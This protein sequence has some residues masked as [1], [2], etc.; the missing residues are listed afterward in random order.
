VIGVVAGTGSLVDTR[1]V[2]VWLSGIAGAIHSERD[3]LTQ[4][5]AAIGDGDHGTNMDRGFTA[6]SQAVAGQPDDLPPGK[7]LVLAGKTRV[8]TVG[9]ASRPLW[10]SAL[11]RA[12]RVLGD[13]PEFELAQ[14]C[15]MFDAALDGVVELGAA[16]PGD[17]TM[18][19]ALGP[20]AGALRASVS[21]GGSVLDAVSSAAAAAA[22]GAA[23]TVPMQA[24]KGRAT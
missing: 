3:Y 10:G 22:E 2:N 1:T 11:R 15:D 16:S 23:A 19:D 6:V 21:N 9:G 18:V 13:A 4:L 5:D 24:R 14:L 7:L 20:A 12:G 17:K 8:S